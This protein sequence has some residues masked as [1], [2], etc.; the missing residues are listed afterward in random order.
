MSLCCPPGDGQGTVGETAGGGGRLG[1]S[2]GDGQGDGRGDSL[3]TVGDG[4]GDSR[5]TDTVG[6][7]LGD[8][9][10]DGRGTGTMGDGR[11]LVGETAALERGAHHPPAVRAAAPPSPQRHWH[12]HPLYWTRLSRPLCCRFRLSSLV[13]SSLHLSRL[14][15]AWPWALQVSPDSFRLLKRAALSWPRGTCSPLLVTIC[16]RRVTLVLWPV[17]GSD[18]LREAGGEALTHRVCLPRPRDA[19]PC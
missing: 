17:G 2:Q 9:R 1:D 6:G 14:R 16:W 3:G 11:G 10:G 8:G 15:Q 19:A 5:G 13:P 12:R 4:W 18:A 7:Q